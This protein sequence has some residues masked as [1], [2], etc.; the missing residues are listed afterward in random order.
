MN[1]E[2]RANSKKANRG[3][4][5]RPLDVAQLQLQEQTTAVF[6]YYGLPLVSVRDV[7]AAFAST[8]WA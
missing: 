8:V 3:Q 1:A 5:V 4:T 7:P 6:A 2:R